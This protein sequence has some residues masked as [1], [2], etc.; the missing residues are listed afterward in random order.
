MACS[1]S[2]TSLLIK[3][4]KT[5]QN[6]VQQHVSYY[7]FQEGVVPQYIFEMF[8]DSA[9]FSCIFTSFVSSEATPSN[10][11]KQM[12]VPTQGKIVILF[13]GVKCSQFDLICIYWQNIILTNDPKPK[14]LNWLNCL[15]VDECCCRL[16]VSPGFTK[17]IIVTAVR[18]IAYVC[19]MM[20]YRF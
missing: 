6:T 3:G 20:L 13:F 16:G 18:T 8:N 12:T 4:V 14:V 5:K 1:E 17:D 19:V 9:A 7:N 11:Q 15:A 2:D 10:E